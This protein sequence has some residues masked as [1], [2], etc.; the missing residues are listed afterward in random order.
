MPTGCPVGVGIHYG[1]G[2]LTLERLGFQVAISEGRSQT[3]GVTTDE[4]GDIRSS[5]GQGCPCHPVQQTRHPAGYSAFRVCG[6]RKHR[7]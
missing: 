4:G 2:V 5:E 7:R 1:G 6:D 3:Q